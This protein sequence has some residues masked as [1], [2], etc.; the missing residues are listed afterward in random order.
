MLNVKD[1]GKYTRSV[2][3]LVPRSREEQLALYARG[4]DD[5]EAALAGLSG[6]DLDQVRSGQWTIRQIVEHVV[7][8]D[9]HWTMCMQVALARPGYTCGHE[10][11]SRKGTGPWAELWDGRDPA[12]ASVV[13]L[14]R[15]N[16][17]HMH[18]VLHHLPAAWNR[19]VTFTPAA[20]QEA[21]TLTVGQMIWRQATHA[22]EHIDEIRQAR[23]MHRC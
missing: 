20:E 4:P 2:R 13:T 14:L 9:A 8:D 23:H 16:R 5:L 22:L 1:P 21:Q 11:F 12:I 10:W 7:A 19:Y 3:P 6:E 18:A 17:T 15:T